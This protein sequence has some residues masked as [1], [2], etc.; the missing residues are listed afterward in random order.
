MGFFN[1]GTNNT[2]TATAATTER[3]PVI[4][5]LNEEQIT[6]SPAEAEGK[7]VA[8]LFSLYA[9]D[10]GDTD[11]ISRFVTAGQIVGG[12]TVVEFGTV[13]RGAI[14]SETKGLG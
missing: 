1:F 9:D 4:L 7:S 2:N 12:N 8:E 10:L 14:T 13:Y 3:K 5:Q 11:R 6:I